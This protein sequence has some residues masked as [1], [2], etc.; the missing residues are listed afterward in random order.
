LVSDEVDVAE[1]LHPGEVVNA[2]RFAELAA[3]YL[4]EHPPENSRDKARFVQMRGELEKKDLIEV[5]RGTG[6]ALAIRLVAQEEDDE[7]AS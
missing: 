1:F 4:G 2:G 3:E 5:K 7:E 6:N